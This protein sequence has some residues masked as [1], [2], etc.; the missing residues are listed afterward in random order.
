LADSGRELRVLHVARDGS[1]LAL[2]DEICARIYEPVLH[3]TRASEEER[4]EH[5][6]RVGRPTAGDLARLVGADTDAE[7]ILCGP[8]PFLGEV[9]EN[10][11]AAGLE[12]ANVGFEAFFS[13]RVVD[14]E[15]REPPEP[16]PFAV[17]FD[18]A[19]AD[20]V[21]A[22]G[23]GS[24]LDVAD[25]AQLS[26]PSA[27]RSGTCGTCAQRVLAG[28]TAYL[29]EPMQEPPAGKTLMCCAVPTSD[30]VVDA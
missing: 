14:L 16:G 2:W 23:D 18:R 22:V 1:D 27:C 20:S 3:M 9:T 4:R 5:G 12:R 15:E 8:T 19:G 7:A 29:V 10:L 30:V 24:L 25:V 28:T 26:L 6:A 13:P 21:W 11:T 17:R